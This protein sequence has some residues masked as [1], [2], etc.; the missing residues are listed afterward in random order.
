[1]GLEDDAEEYE[2]GDVE[3]T[4]DD[5]SVDDVDDGPGDAYDTGYEEEDE[6]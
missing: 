1:M 4:D 5:V 6:R 3:T 2:N